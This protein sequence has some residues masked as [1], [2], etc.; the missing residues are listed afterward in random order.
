M[1]KKQKRVLWRIF[2]AGALLLLL[3]GLSLGGVLP[4]VWYVRLPL[5]L[6]PYFL[7]GWDVLRRALLNVA[8]GQLLDENFLMAIATV[9]AL[10]LGEYAEAVFV[11]LFY[12]VGELFQGIAVGKSR[13]SIAALMDIRPDVARVLREGEELTV[14]PEDVAVGETLVV[15]PGEKI[16]LDGIVTEG[17]SELNTV[18]LTGE[19]L[20]RAVAVG[21]AVVSGCVNVSGL[22]HLRVTRVFGES[23]VSKIL[24]LVESSSLV[25]SKA[26]NAVTKFAHWYTP[27]VV[28]GAFLLALIPSLV[29]GDWMRWLK[30]ALIFLV[31][32]CPCALVISVPLSYFSGIGA[33]SRLGVLVKGGNRLEMLANTDTVV[34]DKTGT[35]TEGSF[36]VTAVHPASGVERERLLRLCYAAE[37]NSNHPIAQ[38]LR[39][40]CDAEGIAPLHADSVTEL[41]GFGI[42]AGIDGKIILVGNA[43]LM[44]KEE[45]SFTSPEEVG[46]IVY[47]AEDG[48]F[49]GSIVISDAVKEDVRQAIMGLR[50]S[51]VRRIVMLTGDRR[52]VAAAVAECLPLDEFHA[53]LLPADKVSCL[54]KLLKEKRGSLV[55]VGDGV[56]DAPVL[57]RADVGIAMGALGSDAAIEAAD[58]VLMDD[59]LPKMTA[60]IRISRFT[61]RTVHQNIVFALGV[62][63]AFLILGIFGMTNMWAATFADVGVAVIAILNAMRTLKCK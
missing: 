61:R 63:A 50:D 25:K 40:A 51:G 32:S 17:Q 8:H 37:E 28:V 48:R 55:F 62:K 52:E 27:A 12:Q 13:R 59:C 20:P 6:I 11:M 56:N 19:S 7:V 22:L 4:E 26:E 47:V 3:G 15:R 1:T 5:F 35:L 41:A 39:D 16:P 34:F 10:V 49:L 44:Q 60:V 57:A 29:T 24:E 36:R 18:S 58:V 46:S 2:C 21:D 31:V 38:S 33:A 53:E 23:T 42:R 14:A 9:G 43:A 30:T 45:V 54:E